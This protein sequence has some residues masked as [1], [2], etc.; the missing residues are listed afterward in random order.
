MNKVKILFNKIVRVGLYYIDKPW[1]NKIYLSKVYERMNDKKIDLNNPKTYAEK[2]NWMKI[3]DRNPL[4]T[5]L[6]DKYN[7][8]EY[9]GQ[10]IGN[11]HVI[12]VL[13]VWNSAD[14]IDIS[15]LPSRFVLKANHDCGSVHICV[16]KEHFDEGNVKKALKKA[17]KQNF[18]WRGREWAYKNVK[19]LI[20]AEEY[21]DNLSDNNYKF[22]CFDGKVKAVYFAPYREKTVDYYDADYNHLD[23][24]TRLHKPAPNSPQKTDKFEEM[25]VLA[26][27]L[28]EGIRAV[29]V[30]L[31][32]ADGKIY[33][34]E[35]TFYHEA[36]FTPFIPDEWNDKFGEWIRL[37]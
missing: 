1:A 4:Y 16:D 18:S 5:K 9:V 28:S 19:P 10:K 3:Y 35:M 30:D 6:V 26:E 23:I 22:F 33:F 11:E 27:K 21:I 31:Y 29:R 32:E 2:I 36:G 34:G 37:D 8:K 15:K 17:L 7:V 20:F 12:P 14:E 25:K 24:Y 13:G